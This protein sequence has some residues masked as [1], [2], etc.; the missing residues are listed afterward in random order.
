MTNESLTLNYRVHKIHGRKH[1]CAT[2][3]LVIALRPAR[4]VVLNSEIGIPNPDYART[5]RIVGQALHVT[6]CEKND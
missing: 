5:T 1:Q 2:T 4:F 6:E 3:T